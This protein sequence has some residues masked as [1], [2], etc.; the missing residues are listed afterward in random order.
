MISRKTRTFVIALVTSASFAATAAVPA[1]SQADKNNGGYKKSI[2]GNKAKQNEGYSCVTQQATYEDFIDLQEQ[3]D[4][5]GNDKQAAFLSE[6]ALKTFEIAK[7]HGCAWVL[8]R[9]KPSQVSPPPGA[10]APG[11]VVGTAS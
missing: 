4:K 3:A 10:T 9:E 6:G 7:A 1:V 8:H 5:E 2:E 11:Q